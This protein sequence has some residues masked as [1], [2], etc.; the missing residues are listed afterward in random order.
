M[1]QVIGLGHVGLYCRE[2][3]TMR[4]FY[5]R[6]LGLTISDEDL[7]RGICFL[8]A[9]RSTRSVR[10]SGTG[11]GEP[12]SGRLVAAPQVPDVRDRS[13]TQSPSSESVPARPSRMKRPAF[14]RP[15]TIRAHLVT[16]VVVALVPVL[17]F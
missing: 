2:L 10:S 5:A 11:P 14:G 8:R 6:V 17:V 16:L 15:F 7:D 3:S 13:A 9:A 1:P 12:I 4:D